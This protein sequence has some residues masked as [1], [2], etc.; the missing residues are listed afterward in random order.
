METYEAPSQE[1][2]DRFFQ[3]IYD[4]MSK[5]ESSEVEHAGLGAM[6][7]NERAV[8]EFVRQ[9]AN[10]LAYL[11]DVGCGNGHFA[12]SLVAMGVV[13]AAD[14]LDVSERSVSL[15]NTA[16]QRLGLRARFYH[17]SICHSQIRKT[18][19]VVSA[20]EVVEHVYSPTRVLD[21]LRDALRPGGVFVGSVPDG[22]SCDNPTHLHHFDEESLRGLL[23]R[24]FRD[25]DI[26][27]VRFNA[28]IPEEGHL[29]FTCRKDGG[30]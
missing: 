26:M 15:A 14:G 30:T 2:Q 24:F 22:F 7:E 8:L 25:A 27:L 6:P 11:L 19:D 18:Y 28:R 4:F 20:F 5:Y 10:P 23:C 1:M 13:A 21:I 9:E 29:V 12:L 3:G 16:A 17:S